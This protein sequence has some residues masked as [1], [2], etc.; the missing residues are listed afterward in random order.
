MSALANQAQLS[1][2]QGLINR[3]LTLDPKAMQRLQK[4]DGKSLRIQCHEPG[5]DVVIHIANEAINLSPSADF[6]DSQTDDKKSVSCHLEGELSAYGKLL[7]ANDKA[8][9]L[10][11]ADLR[12][13]GD[14]SLLI[15]LEQIL[16]QT[17]LDWEFHLAKLIGDL[18]A[19]FIGQKSRQ[20]WHFLR[21]SQPVFMRH[22]QEFILEE[23]QLCPDKITLE[24]FI[25]DVQSLDERTER[26]Q[27]KIQRLTKRLS[28]D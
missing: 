4:L 20:G 10:I 24:K 21:K 23:A 2:L 15:E 14:S 25:D 27:A 9:A 13:Q 19:H 26:L 8:A 16:S 18:P 12:L 22:L 7:A 11:N 1:V 5:A 28:A 3:A 17:E 6:L